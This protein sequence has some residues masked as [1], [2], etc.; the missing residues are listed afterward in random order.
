MAYCYET[1]GNID[2]AQEQYEAMLK[3][4][5]QDMAVARLAVDF[6]RRTNRAEPAEALLQSLLG[7]KPPL[8][9]ADA[10]WARREFARFLGVSGKYSDIQKA[11]KLVE[12]NLSSPQ[13]SLADQQLIARLLASDMRRSGRQRG[14]R[15]V[16]EHGRLR[17]AGRPFRAGQSVSEGGRLD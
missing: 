4:V 16:R 17:H 2:A 12:Q 14:D 3:A 15:D 1:I 11:K 5:P 7:A 13:A 10:A 6:Y 8:A 9:D